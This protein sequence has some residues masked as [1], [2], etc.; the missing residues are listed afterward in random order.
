[1]L[2]YAEGEIFGAGHSIGGL[3]FK[4]AMLKSPTV[5]IPDL[6]R[7]PVFKSYGFRVFTLL[8]PE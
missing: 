4:R 8:R 6:I 7:H 5:V 1:M 2:G 3:K